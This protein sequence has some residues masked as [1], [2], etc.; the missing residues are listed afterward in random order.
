MMLAVGEYVDVLYHQGMAR[1][2]HVDPQDRGTVAFDR[3]AGVGLRLLFV[4][5][6][7]QPVPVIVDVPAGDFPEMVH[8]DGLAGACFFRYR[9]FQVIAVV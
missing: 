1:P 7:S 2:V 5:A 8:R 9:I 4:Q 3:F 6:E